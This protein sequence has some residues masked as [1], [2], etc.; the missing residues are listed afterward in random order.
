MSLEAWQIELRRQFGRE[1]A[2]KLKNLG[3][4]PVFSDFQVT[5]PQ[6]KS[7]YRVATRAARS[8]KQ[9]ASPYA[10]VLTGTPLENRL[11]ELV[12]IIQ[13][14][15]RHRL[16]PTSRFLA[17]HQIHDPS[18]AQPD[19]WSGLLQTGLAILE[20]LATATR[21]EPAHSPRPAA[22]GLSFIHRDAQTGETYL[23]FPAPTPDVL[24]RVLGAVGSLLERFRK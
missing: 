2:F 20:Q 4:Q 8:V 5:N 7:T 6:S 9:I 23:K 3:D 13:F 1:Q 17:D 21:P 12:S 14:V 18:T 11:E 10:I 22:T 19:P 16:G 24:D 15:D